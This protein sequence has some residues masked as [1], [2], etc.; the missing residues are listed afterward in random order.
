[1]KSLALPAAALLAAACAAVPP[2]PIALDG[3]PAAFEMAGRMSVARAGRGDIFRIRWSHAPGADRW[4]LST[5][6][7]NEV[8]RIDRDG[9]SITV[10]R[11]G[12]APVTASS[13]SELTGNLLGA[14]LDERL[15]VAWLHARPAAGPEGWDVT[16]GETARFGTTEVGRRITASRDDVRVKLVVDDYRA[17]PE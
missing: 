17:R 2:A 7:G 4:V 13:F 10:H 9:A 14:A 3:L 8:A 16:I 11:P 12:E 1:V 15:L 5:P 6:V